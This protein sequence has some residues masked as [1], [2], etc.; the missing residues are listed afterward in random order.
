MRNRDPAA[1][2]KAL[3]T[4]V[5]IGLRVQSSTFRADPLYSAVVVVHKMAA[6]IQTCKLILAFKILDLPFAL[7]ALQGNINEARSMRFDRV[8][9]LLSRVL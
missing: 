6:G 4:D 2:T 9:N 7:F 1:T 3:K 5:N 8:D